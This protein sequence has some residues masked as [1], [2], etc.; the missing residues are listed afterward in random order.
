MQIL[1]DSN[2]E[3][4]AAAGYHS[5]VVVVHAVL[6]LVTSEDVACMS[7]TTEYETDSMAPP[8]SSRH[9]PQCAGPVSHDVS[10]ATFFVVQVGVCTQLVLWYSA[11]ATTCTQRVLL[12]RDGILL[13]SWRPVLCSSRP[14]TMKSVLLN[15]AWAT[16]CSSDAT[17]EVV[18][19][20]HS[21]PTCHAVLYAITL[22]ASTQLH[23]IQEYTTTPQHQHHST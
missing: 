23:A 2:I 10:T 5:N 22:L 17:Y 14:T 7:S 3:V 13:L 12:A 19:S 4:V 20:R 9:T 18:D 1:S 15:I 6:L 16:R 8:T 11:H 21:T